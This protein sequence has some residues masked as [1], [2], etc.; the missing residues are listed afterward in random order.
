[1]AVQG[2]L[3]LSSSCGH[4]KSIASH[5]TILSEEDVGAGQT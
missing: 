4:S 1:M 5:A 2:D 3:E